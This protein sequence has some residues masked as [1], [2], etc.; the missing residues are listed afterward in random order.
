MKWSYDLSG[1]EEIQRDVPVYDASATVA[2]AIGELLMQGTTDA[3]SSTDGK[4]A[5]VTGYTGDNAEVVRA[6]GICMETVADG[7]AYA[8]STNGFAYAK[9][10]INPFA[11]Y[12]AEYSQ[13]TVLTAVSSSTTTFTVTRLEDDID[14]SWI[15]IVTGSPA[16]NTGSLRYIKT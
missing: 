13:D 12:K 14:G 15:F 7:T 1:A 5:F 4:Q 9:A 10:I 8:G 16:G 2:F 11:V 6:L 3:D